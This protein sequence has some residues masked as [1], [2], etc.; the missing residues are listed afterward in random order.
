[1]AEETAAAAAREAT[2]A[3]ERAT[4]EFSLQEVTI[5]RTEAEEQLAALRAREACLTADLEAASALHE[6]LEG[7]PLLQ[8]WYSKLPRIRFCQVFWG[9]GRAR[10]PP[11][12]DAQK[13]PGCG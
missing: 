3:E 2:A 7:A 13:R 8:P 5:A 4:L 12:V 11:A 10:R 9:S 1:M 6:Q